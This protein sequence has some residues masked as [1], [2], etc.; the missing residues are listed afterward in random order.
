MGSS[1]EPSEKLIVKVEK[2][3]QSRRIPNSGCVKA[4]QALIPV[5]LLAS[6][7]RFS[8]GCSLDDSH[9]AGSVW[10]RRTLRLCVKRD[11]D[12]QVEL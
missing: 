8:L 4:S 3:Q 7:V 10:R 9:D 11:G 2:V 12:R 5:L 6:I 1:S